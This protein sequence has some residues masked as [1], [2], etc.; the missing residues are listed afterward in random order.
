MESFWFWVWRYLH[1]L[2]NSEWDSFFLKFP[3]LHHKSPTHKILINNKLQKQPSIGVPIKSCSENMQQIHRRTPMLKCYFN[4]WRAATAPCYQ[5]DAYHL[6][7]DILS[8]IFGCTS[9]WKLLTISHWV[10]GLL[11]YSEA[12]VQR[13]SVKKV[14][15][16]ISQN[17]QE[18]TCAKVS[19]LIKLQA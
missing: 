11:H 2:G 18:N 6:V 19:F 3:S 9:Y 12:V 4:L 17:S 13:C 5:I 8:K 15:L 14:V 10:S 1:V 7:T 16:E